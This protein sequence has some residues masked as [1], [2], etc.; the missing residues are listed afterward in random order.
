VENLRATAKVFV[1]KNI[2]L[3][4]QIAFNINIS[5]VQTLSPRSFVAKKLSHTDLTDLT[6]RIQ[7]Q[8]KL[9]ANFI[10]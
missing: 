5:F 8:S 3:I 4:P 7:H 6:D 2:A 9:C 10:S 1:V